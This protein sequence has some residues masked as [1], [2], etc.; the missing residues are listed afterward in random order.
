MLVEISGIK[1][2]PIKG[3]KIAFAGSRHWPV[4]RKHPQGQ[5]F[6]E[7]MERGLSYME[8]HGI[9]QQAYLECGFFHPDIAKWTVL[10]PP[11]LN[12][13]NLVPNTNSSK[14]SPSKTSPA[15]NN[16]SISNPS[17]IDQS[18]LK[19]ANLNPANPTR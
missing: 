8:A 16:P 11:D 15:N 9:I 10:N 14:T 18:T 1:L 2:V 12:S 4:S 17:T 5:A 6:Y 19:P 7:A 13:S 3:I